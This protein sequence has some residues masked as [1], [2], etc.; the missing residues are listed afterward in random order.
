VCILDIDVLFKPCP[1]DGPTFRPEAVAE[2]GKKMFPYMKDPNTGNFLPP[3]QGAWVVVVTPP[4]RPRCTA[5]L[6]RR[7][8]GAH[9]PMRLQGRV[10]L[11]EILSIS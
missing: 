4:H 8:Q 9:T 6:L 7:S 10:L 5:Q 1:M 11:F 3:R 2:G